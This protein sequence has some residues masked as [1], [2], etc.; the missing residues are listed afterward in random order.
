MTTPDL[1]G[2]LGVGLILIAYGLLQTGRI[3][4]RDRRFSAANALGAA[5]ILVSLWFAPNVSAIAI[6]TA[7]L[8]ISLYG[9]L[10]RQPSQ[11]Q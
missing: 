1:L 2:L 3:E 11:N 4:P 8:G 7:W 9:L 5:L 6:E 10:R